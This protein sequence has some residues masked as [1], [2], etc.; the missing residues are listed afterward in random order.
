MKVI[1]MEDIDL[2]S[3]EEQTL[4]QGRIRAI[5]ET[6]HIA[7]VLTIHPKVKEIGKS[8]YQTR[9]L[10]NKTSLQTIFKDGEQKFELDFGDKTWVDIEWDEEKKEYTFQ[11]RSSTMFKVAEGKPLPGRSMARMKVSPKTG[12]IKSDWLAR[13]IFQLDKTLD[14][15]DQNTQYHFLL[16]PCESNSEDVERGIKSGWEMRLLKEEPAEELLLGTEVDEN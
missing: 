1:S 13:L 3:S 2:A 15:M 5:M 12:V 10:L 11:K 8:E 14:K 16:M 4:I 6:P 9:C 7:P